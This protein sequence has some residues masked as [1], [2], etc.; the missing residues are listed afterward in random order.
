MEM[1]ISYIIKGQGRRELAQAVS[2]VL[3][4]VPIYEGVPSCA[5]EIGDCVWTGRAVQ[6]PNCDLNIIPLR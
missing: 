5:Y 1:K 3:N 6:T 4:I 2:K